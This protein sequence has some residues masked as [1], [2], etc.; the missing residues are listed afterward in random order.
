[1]SELLK[2]VREADEHNRKHLDEAR[3]EFERFLWMLASNIPPKPKRRALYIASG[4]GAA[5]EH[6]ED[7][8]VIYHPEAGN[9]PSLIRKANGQIEPL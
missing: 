4:N 3:K 5:E 9:G 8:S 6:L 7:G 1:M 2:K